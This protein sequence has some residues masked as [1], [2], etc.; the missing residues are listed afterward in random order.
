MPSWRAIVFNVE[1][2]PL[3]KGLVVPWR[4]RGLV[5][6]WT[7]SWSRIFTTSRGAMQKLYRRHSPL[8]HSMF[9]SDNHC[10]KKGYLP[11]H[12]TCHSSSYDDLGS[13]A[14]KDDALVNI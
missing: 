5:R 13:F 12:Q 14:L 3:Y 6:E 8:C 4:K 1:R 9:P 2:V 11:R 7:W 10:Q